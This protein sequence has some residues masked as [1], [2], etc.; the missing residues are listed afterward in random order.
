[1][2][3]I[4]SKYAVSYAREMKKIFSESAILWEAAAYP[5]YQD[6]DTRSRREL[7]R[8]SIRTMIRQHH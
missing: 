2:N 1:M 8:F 5:L 6:A 7:L 3:L 4:E